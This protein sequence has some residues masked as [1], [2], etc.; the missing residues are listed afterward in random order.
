MNNY[1]NENNGMNERDEDGIKMTCNEI[2][3]FVVNRWNSISP[4]P[5]NVAYIDNFNGFYPGILGLKEIDY[6]DSISDGDTIHVVLIADRVEK[7]IRNYWYIVS[8]DMEFDT[9]SNFWTTMCN[10]M[11]ME[12]NYLN[13]RVLTIYDHVMSGKYNDDDDRINCG[14]FFSDFKST[15]R[16]R[17]KTL[18]EFLIKSDVTND[19]NMSRFKGMSDN[20]KTVYVQTVCDTYLKS[21]Y[22]PSDEVAMSVMINH[23][24]NMIPL[25]Y[26]INLINEDHALDNNDIDDDFYSTCMDHLSNLCENNFADALES[27]NKATKEKNKNRK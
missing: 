6:D 5:V 25:I 17:I 1:M 13:S 7:L 10:F 2:I 23:M 20:D 11:I 4:A 21:V 12:M 8:E 3:S 16:G 26:E 24:Y 15:S 27:M 9:W 18:E 14:K 22:M 19:V